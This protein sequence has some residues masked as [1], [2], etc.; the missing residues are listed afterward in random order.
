MA[1]T[2]SRAY[3]YILTSTAM[4]HWRSSSFIKKKTK[5]VATYAHYG[6]KKSILP[7]HPPHNASDS[8]Y[9]K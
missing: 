3:I 6:R 4:N 5:E 1:Q 7:K 8:E 9:K 2:N